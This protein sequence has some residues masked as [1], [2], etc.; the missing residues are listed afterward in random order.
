[1]LD[2]SQTIFGGAYFM[3]KYTKEFK[4]KLVKEY[5]KGEL[6]CKSLAKK[7]NIASTPLRGWIKRYKEH[8]IKGL[9]RNNVSYDGNFKISV[10][11]YMHNNHLSLTETAS[12]YNLGNANIIAKWEQ[13]YYEEGPQSL[14]SE[15]R[16]RKSKISSKPNK[17]KISKA[18]E[19]DL[20]EEVQYLRMENAYLK[21]LHALIQERDNPQKKKK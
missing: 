11:E 15:K 5:L 9:E 12:K 17:K 1:M 7:Y 13:I 2:E 14:F 8:E 3:S 19:K 16:G 6:G 20:I 4:L 18:T 21:K 10:V